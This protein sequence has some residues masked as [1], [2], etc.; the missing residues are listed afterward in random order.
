M[1][2]GA[3]INGTMFSLPHQVIDFPVSI[4]DHLV[5]CKFLKLN[6]ISANIILGFELFTHWSPISIDY[7]QLIFS[8]TIF[9]NSIQI[10]LNSSCTFFVPHKKKLEQLKPAKVQKKARIISFF[11]FLLKQETFLLF[12]KPKSKVTISTKGLKISRPT[13]PMRLNYQG[14]DPPNKLK[15]KLTDQ[16][17]PMITS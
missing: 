2:G 3:N 13:K 16:I 1:E 10:P 9:D 15:D 7:H 4:Q 17:V 14:C 8:M 6:D 5:Q 12:Q 11:P